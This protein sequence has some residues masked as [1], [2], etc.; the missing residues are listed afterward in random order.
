MPF[1]PVV[2]PKNR[3]HVPSELLKRGILSQNMQ[4]LLAGRQ[5]MQDSILKT[6]SLRKKMQRTKK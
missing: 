2:Q 3:D 1:H 5:L 4:M 6:V